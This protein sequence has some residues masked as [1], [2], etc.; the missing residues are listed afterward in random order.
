M[1]RVMN[2]INEAVMI[3]TRIWVSSREMLD[4]A[5]HYISKSGLTLSCWILSIVFIMGRFAIGPF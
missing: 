5:I 1:Q 4:G 3:R 2:L